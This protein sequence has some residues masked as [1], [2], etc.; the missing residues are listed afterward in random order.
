LKKFTGGYT[1][2]PVLKGGEG[3]R[4][5][6][7]RRDGRKGMGRKER[8][9]GRKEGRETERTEDSEGWCTP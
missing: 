1:P 6:W 2:N 4:E 7:I 9:W 8:W 3:K 5:G